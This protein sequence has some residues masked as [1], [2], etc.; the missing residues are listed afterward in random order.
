MW[1]QASR[2]NPLGSSGLKSST[3]R[4][5]SSCRTWQG[6]EPRT[7]SFKTTRLEWDGRHAGKRK[8]YQSDSLLPQEDLNGCAVVAHCCLRSQTR[9]IFSHR[10]Q[11]KDIFISSF[12][13]TLK[14]QESLEAA[15]PRAKRLKSDVPISGGRVRHLKQAA[16]AVGLR[17]QQVCGR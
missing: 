17:R 4:V 9:L 16:D 8:K 13:Q 14:I 11:L 3:S 7:S 2:S 10:H 15:W 12:K 1:D 5:S 6:F